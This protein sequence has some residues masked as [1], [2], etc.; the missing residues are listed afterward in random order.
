MI[1]NQRR[2]NRLDFNRAKERKNRL[3][4]IYNQSKNEKLSILPN[5]TNFKQTRNSDLTMIVRVHFWD[6]ATKI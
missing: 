5:L 4:R 1:I 2:E 3:L 6:L